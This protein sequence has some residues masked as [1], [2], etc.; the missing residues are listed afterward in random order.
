MVFWILFSKKITVV[1]VIFQFEI[2]SA[3]FFIV[4]FIIVIIIFVIF[5]VIVIKVVIFVIQETR[6]KFKL[7][8]SYN[9]FQFSFVTV[10]YFH[11]FF[12]ILKVLLSLIWF[13]ITDFGLRF[14]LPN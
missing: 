5:F 7:V 2:Q 8:I 3:A 14:D 6:T 13:Q 4:I 1:V 12:D 11:S 9:F 10:T